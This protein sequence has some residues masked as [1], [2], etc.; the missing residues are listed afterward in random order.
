M[1]E[2]TFTIRI[3]VIANHPKVT[4]DHLVHQ[5][6]QY[7]YAWILSTVINIGVRRGGGARVGARLP[8]SPPL[9]SK[10]N[11]HIGGHFPP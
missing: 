8:T 2:S 11:S 10:Q 9:K 4:A 6:K 3:I 7:Q 5:E 1:V